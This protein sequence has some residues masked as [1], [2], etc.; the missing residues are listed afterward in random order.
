MDESLEQNTPARAKRSARAV[1]S[2]NQENAENPASS[3]N[4][5][6]SE[7]PHRKV[8]LRKTRK[9][10]S[11]LF[12]LL[13]LAV[14]CLV[15]LLLYLRTQTL[16]DAHVP[17]TSEIVDMHGEVIDR[18]HYGQNRQVISLEQISPYLVNATLSIEDHRFYQHPGIDMIGVARAAWV[19]L[20][21]RAMVQGASSITQQLARNLYLTHEKTWSRKIK[22]ALLT[23]QLEMKF[24]KKEILTQYLNQ[25]YYGH[26]TYGI[27]A[28]ARLYFDKEAR[29]LTLAESALLAGVPKGPK[30]FS[31][32]MNEANAKGRQ[33]VVLQA[34]VTRGFINQ[35]QA[36]AAA[37]EELVFMPLKGSE[38]AA[39]PY[40][41][42]YVRQQAVRLLGLD[43][44]AFNEGGFH[45][46]TTL[47]LRA[48]RIAEEIVLKHLGEKELQV[49]LISLDP[50]TGY[51][52]AMVG[53]RDYRE[54]QY[55]RV[56]ARARQP[57]S[58][59]KPIVY[60]A[61][62]QHPGFSAV[63]RY[64]SEPT[65]FRYDEGRE[66]YIPR[67]FGNLYPHADIDLRQAISKSDNIYAVHTIME[68]GP[69]Q[70]VEIARK[71]GIQSPMQPLPSLALGT[72]PVSPFEMASAFAVISNQG[73]RVEPKV[74]TRIENGMGDVL[75]EDKPVSEQVIDPAYTYVLTNLMEGVFDAGGTGYR[76]SSVLK[77]PVAAK[78][79]TTNVD[80]W[81]V[82]FTPELSTAVWVGY[83]RDHRISSAESTLAAPIFAEFM[84]RTLE[85]VPPKLFPVPDN[86][87]SFYI[88]PSSGKIATAD[89]PAPRLESFVSGTEPTE[90]CTDHHQ[91][92]TE[93]DEWEL[94]LPP[95]EF[96]VETKH[97]SWWQDLKKW[98]SE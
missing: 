86:V 49:A 71:L 94:D 56:F 75:Y 77:R 13:L 73:L 62:L 32:Y 27:E 81:M 85:A 28:A 19:D 37:S 29:D 52:K 42:D 26:A 46:H 10:F 30:Y 31:P 65:V 40:F 4:P 57:G 15:V 12:S 33:R 7:N 21:H 98:W 22:E 88:E 16:P 39:A 72:Y 66:T 60:L 41:R 18:F 82:G 44:E 51:V 47:D 95:T 24:S 90:Y 6:H 83:D 74:I 17:E 69:E 80:A 8:A 25:I 96:D 92:Q 35:R 14:I 5:N 76:V 9:L 23:L 84:E 38:P 93:L 34:M 67:N 48:Q 87:V 64:K 79:G 11:F 20:Q 91:V 59:F 2:R 54:N 36:Q 45:I 63:T 61:A 89:C 58:A 78:T 97:D 43:E 55:N 68:I 1:K 50:R 53:G 3:D 70:V